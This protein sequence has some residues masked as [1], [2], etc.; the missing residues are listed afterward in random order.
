MRCH[1]T[2]SNRESDGREV[3]SAPK[4]APSRLQRAV[5]RWRKGPRQLCMALRCTSRPAF[6]RSPCASESACGEEDVDEKGRRDQIWAAMRGR[7]KRLCL[8]AQWLPCGAHLIPRGRIV[9]CAHHLVRRSVTLRPK[10]RHA[11][12]HQ[13]FV[14]LHPPPLFT[15]S[16]SILE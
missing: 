15:G 9:A 10:E 7:D 1:H 3:L 2:G 6:R 8:P 13:D 5:K 4:H 14:F 11:S 12:L 16:S